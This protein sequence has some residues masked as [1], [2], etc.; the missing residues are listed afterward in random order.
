MSEAQRNSINDKVS[1]SAEGSAP[2]ISMRQLQL[3]NIGIQC[4]KDKGGVS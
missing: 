1:E 2:L 3:V 4:A